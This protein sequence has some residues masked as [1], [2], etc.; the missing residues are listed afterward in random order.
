MS[1][2]ATILEIYQYTFGLKNICELSYEMQCGIFDVAPDI[3]SL[4][5]DDYFITSMAPYRVDKQ[6]IFLYASGGMTLDEVNS[7]M[8]G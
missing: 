3:Y 6:L 8:R 2:G 4:Y 5:V 1:Y 7:S